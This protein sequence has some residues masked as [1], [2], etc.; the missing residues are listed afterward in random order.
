MSQSKHIRLK[1]H[2][3]LVAHS[4]DVVEIRYGVWNPVSF[5]LTDESES[6]HL[7][8]LLKALDGSLSE[9]ELA[10]REHVP[11]AEVEALIDHLQQLNVMEQGASSALDFYL[12]HVAPTL[13]AYGEE[14]PAAK[15]VLLMGDPELTREIQRNLQGDIPHAGVTILDRQDPTWRALSAQDTT[16]LMDGLAFEEWA[17]QFA[18]WRQQFVVLA[19]RTI[20]PI[21]FKLLNR[22]SLHYGIAWLHAVMDGPLLMVGPLFIPYRSACYECFEMRVVMNLREGASYLRYK[23]ALVQHQIEY[24]AVP[25]EP[26]LLNLLASHTALEV[27]NFVLTDSAFVV[28]KVLAIYL[29]TMEFSYNEVL[30]LPGCPACSPAAARDDKELYFD[31]RSLINLRALDGG[32]HG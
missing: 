25:A 13:R 19:S 17:E 6:G 8:P 1:R 28:N 26:V 15:P 24:G 30:R 11:V 4:A 23:E 16:V 27:L 18:G 22:I 2:Y 20:N 29:P 14:P 5:T 12:D 32:S 31:I 3:S 21:Q 9:A 7:Y 10:A